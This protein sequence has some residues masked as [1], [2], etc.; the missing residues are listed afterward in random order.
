MATVTFSRICSSTV[1]LQ[2]NCSTR[3]SPATC[4]VAST[5][6]SVPS[7]VSCAGALDLKMGP[8][9]AS[10]GTSCRA[11]AD[12][13]A[14]AAA[15]AAVG[16]A[17]EGLVPYDAPPLGGALTGSACLGTVLRRK[18]ASVGPSRY[19]CSD[20]SRLA[21][22]TGQGLEM[23]SGPPAPPSSCF[24]YSVARSRT[25]SSLSYSARLSSVTMRGVRSATDAPNSASDDTAAA[26]TVA[27]SRMMRL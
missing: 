4:L 24:R 26:R 21:A 10:S 11:A 9:A 12:S 2:S 16:A 15:A 25:S 8:T 18:G 1:L 6:Y 23:A 3:H 22:G 19:E 27:F 5:L 20:F 14:V 13:A 7:S 17:V